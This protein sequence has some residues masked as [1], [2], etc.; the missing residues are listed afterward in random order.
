MIEKVHFQRGK[1]WKC[2]ILTNFEFEFLCIVSYAFQPILNNLQKLVG[3]WAPERKSRN[4]F[5]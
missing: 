1:G 3:Y 2:R 5:N 4:Y